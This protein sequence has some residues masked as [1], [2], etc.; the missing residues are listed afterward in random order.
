M[1]ID[2]A[3]KISLVDFLARLG[4][5]PTKV[6]GQ[7]YWY[8]SPYRNERH[9]S[10][11]VNIE[12]NRW[13]DFGTGEGGSIIKLARRIYRVEDISAVLRMI[14][15]QIPSPAFV[16]NKPPCIV[17]EAPPVME[18]VEISPLTHQALLGYLSKRGISQDIAR[19]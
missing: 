2:E 1:N 10:F 6:K 5:K 13:Y 8:L 16:L 7:K 17:M 14:E 9:A 3:F 18:N 19:K 15:Q 12:K 4:H 11:N